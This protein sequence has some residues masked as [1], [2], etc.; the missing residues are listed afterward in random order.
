MNYN[1]LQLLCFASESSPRWLWLICSMEPNSLFLRPTMFFFSPELWMAI[2]LNGI[3][4]FNDFSIFSGNEIRCALLLAGIGCV[5]FL[6]FLVCLFSFSRIWIRWIYFC[7]LF[8]G[9]SSATALPWQ[10][11][12]PIHNSA[13]CIRRDLRL[14][15]VASDWLVDVEIHLS[16]DCNTPARGKISSRSQGD[17]LILNAIFEIQQNIGNEERERERE[18]TTRTKMP[19]RRF[20]IAKLLSI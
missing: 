12:V 17:Y 11:S 16:M 5:H 18:K 13:H 9:W 2:M 7:T 4:Y 20:L 10:P 3:D 6:L 8:T 14:N 15:S 19:R 1:Q